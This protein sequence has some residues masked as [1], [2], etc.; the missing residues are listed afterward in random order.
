MFT[1]IITDIGRVLRLQRSAAGAHLAI[2]TRLAAR[3]LRAGE[4]VAVGGVCLTVEQC[5]GISFSCTASP[6]TLRRTTL[7]RL[8]PGGRVNLERAL[9]PTTRMGGH[10][11]QGHVD[12][13]GQ[14]RRMRQE[15]NSRVLTIVA[16]AVLRPHLVDRGSIAVD[17]VSLTITGVLEAGFQV[18]LIPA[19][20]EAT[21][22]DEK[23]AGSE[24]NLEA[25]I[26]SKYLARQ[27]ENRKDIRSETGE[28]AAWLAATGTI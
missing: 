8:G 4:S 2:R 21:T 20:L 15:G 26:L 27:L 13:V 22:L 18:T 28:P 17:G 1:G 12:G 25:D 11:V 23:R 9:T 16:P 5:D 7:S 6:E 24:V 19:T 14:V 10:F 3:D